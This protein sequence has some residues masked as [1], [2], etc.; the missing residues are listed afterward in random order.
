MI[1]PNMDEQTPSA[2]LRGS[3]TGMHARLQGSH[4]LQRGGW[5]FK[6][7]LQFSDRCY[8]IPGLVYT[9][10]RM[11][12]STYIVFSLSAARLDQTSISFHS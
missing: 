8:S 7:N 10:Y 6:E 5:G 11:L 2:L 9:L 3:V 12:C 1:E 4:Y